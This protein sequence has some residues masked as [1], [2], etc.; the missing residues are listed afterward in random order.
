MSLKFYQYTFIYQS[1]TF[2]L[3]VTILIIT[4]LSPYFKTTH[5]NMTDTLLKF[6]CD[7][8]IKVMGKT[9]NDFENKIISLIQQHCP[10][11]SRDAMTIRPSKKGNYVA[12]TC[13][14]MAENQPQLD[15]IYRDLSNH[16]AVAMA[17]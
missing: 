6:P 10:Y 8:P 12:L 7:F 16:P 14:I 15:A 9:K 11:F 4:R 17:L 1:S 13:L 2:F 3:Y 5:T